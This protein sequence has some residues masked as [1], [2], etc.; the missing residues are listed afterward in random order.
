MTSMHSSA[1]IERLR[2]MFA[3]YG[4]PDL[5]VSDNGTAFTSR[6]MQSFLK[7]NGIEYMHTA[8]YHPASNGRAER[9]VRELKCALRKQ[10]Q[11]SLA[12]KVSRFLFKQHSTPHSESGKTP[13]ELMLGRNLRSG[14]SKLHPDAMDVECKRQPPEQSFQCGDS[15][16]ARNF[17]QGP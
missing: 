16:Y 6:D 8:P 2:K 4:L 3:T 12:C 7:L 10:R 9:M 1:V 15:V 11:G 17:R 13:A 14:L 5:I